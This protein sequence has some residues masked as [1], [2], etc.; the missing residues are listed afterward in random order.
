[1]L[2]DLR[3]RIGSGELIGKLD[4]RSSLAEHYHVSPMTIQR[5]INQL[6]TDGVVCSR[7]GLGVWV[8]HPPA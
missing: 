7:R 3:S 8:A 6:K 1:V 5:A 4:T 2:D